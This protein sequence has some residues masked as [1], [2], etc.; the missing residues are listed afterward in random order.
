MNHSFI[1]ANLIS[2]TQ[3]PQ[4]LYQIGT[5]LPRFWDFQHAVAQGS[6]MV[7]GLRPVALP[8]SVASSSHFLGTKVPRCGWRLYESPIYQVA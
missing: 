8:R 3:T 5:I 4:E 6:N 1:L 2:I 7:Q